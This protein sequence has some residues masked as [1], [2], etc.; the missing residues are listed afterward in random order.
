[1]RGE[2][3]R[4]RG[5]RRAYAC[6]DLCIYVNTIRNFMKNRKDMHQ[7]VYTAILRMGEGPYSTLF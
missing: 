5:G 7:I 6:T 2:G 3:R 4:E 1:M